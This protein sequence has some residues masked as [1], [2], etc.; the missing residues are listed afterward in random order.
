MLCFLIFFES[1]QISPSQSGSFLPLRPLSLP[2]P[3]WSLYCLL[4]SSLLPTP[5]GR[6]HKVNLITFKVK[7][8]LMK[9]FKTDDPAPAYVKPPPSS[10]HNPTHTWATVL[11][12]HSTLSLFVLPKTCFSSFLMDARSSCRSDGFSL[13]WKSHL[14]P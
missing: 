3:H 13:L 2:W 9:T 1:A 10:S 14:T 8:T 6:F 4:L 12:K 11:Q 7:S 5:S